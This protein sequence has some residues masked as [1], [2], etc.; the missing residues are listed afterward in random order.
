MWYAPS[1]RWTNDHSRNPF[2]AARGP[3]AA[4]QQG[5]VALADRRVA[6]AG[7]EC[8]A[9]PAGRLR[10]ISLP[11]AKARR[12]LSVTQ[13][14]QAQFAAAQEPGPSW[15]ERK[16]GGDCATNI[17]PAEQR[18][19]LASGVIGIVVGL[20]ILAVLLV[21]DADRLWRLALLPVFWGAASGYFQWRDKT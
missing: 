15:P 3:S 2:A 13:L 12:K 17:S 16:G 5:N 20:V 7:R 14:S 18:K 19:R 11:A 6:C 10:R 9:V 21:A 1:W 8:R 4:D